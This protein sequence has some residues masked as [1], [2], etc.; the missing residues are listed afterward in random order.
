MYYCYFKVNTWAVEHS[1]SENR[2][3]SPTAWF[4]P[5]FVTMGKLLRLLCLG[6]HLL[7]TDPTSQGCYEG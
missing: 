6:F 1:V 5:D 4:F 3:W 2:I 7:N